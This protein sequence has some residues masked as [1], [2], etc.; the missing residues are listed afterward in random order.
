MKK[1]VVYPSPILR[2]ETEEIKK[3][4]QELEEQIENVKEILMKTDNGAGLAAPQIGEA[5]RFFG[6][7]SHKEE[8]VR[9]FINPRIINVY[10]ERVYPKL[11]DDKGN[12]EDFLE[13][14]LSF[15]DYFG[16]VKRFLKV[17]VEWEEIEDGKLTPKKATL[18]GLDAIVFQHERDHLDG[19]LFVDYIKE[20]GGKFYKQMPKKMAVWSVDKVINGEL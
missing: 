9:I 14:C 11:V 20:E 16:T 12:E 13:G 5:M 3:V 8:S 10:G 18:K 1:I 15:P 4:T 6:L 17:D 19:I 7:K 2:K